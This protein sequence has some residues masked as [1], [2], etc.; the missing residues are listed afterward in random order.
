M[1]RRHRDVLLHGQIVEQLDRLPRAGETQARPLVRRL[2]RQVAA[3]EHHAAAVADEAGDRVDE[4]R[5]AGAVR[6]DQ[7]EELSGL[8]LQVDVDQRPHAAE[9]DRHPVRFQHGSHRS[10]LL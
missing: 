7:A 1:V 2:P 9:A 5:L 3:V 6:S 4:R 8:D 10:T